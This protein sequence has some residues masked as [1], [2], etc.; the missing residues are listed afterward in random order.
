MTGSDSGTA[1]PGAPLELS[2]ELSAAGFE[3]AHEIGRGGFGIVFRCL[4]PS[5]DR[6]VAVKVLTSSL[7]Q[8]NLERFL[9]EQRAMGRLSGHPNIVNV[10]QVGATRG[11][12]PYIVMQ[13]HPRDSLDVRIRRDG[14]LKWDDALF[15]GVKMAGALETAHQLDVL[16]RDVKP[17]NILLTAYGDPQLTDFGIAHMAGAFE[18]TAGTVTGSPAFTAPEVLAGDSPSPRSDIYG[19]GATLFCAITGHAPFERHAGEQ[20]VAQFLRITTQPIPDLREHHIPDDVC[21]AIEHAMARS[22]ADRPAAAADFGQQLRAAEL[23]HSLP[24]DDMALPTSKNVVFTSTETTQAGPART[25]TDRGKSTATLAIGPT[26]PTS[27]AERSVSMPTGPRGEVGN[28]PL[29][30]TSFVGRRHALFEAKKTLSTSRLVTLTGMG[31]VGKTRLALR[32]AADTRRGFKDG[33]WLI[34]LGELHDAMLV[35]ATVATTLGIRNQ[36]ADPPRA[37]LTN[38]LMDRQLLLVL[39]NCEHLVETVAALAKTLLRACPGVRILATSREPLG[40][41]GEAAIRV[42]PLEVPDVDR[43]SSLRGLHQ[44]ESVNLFTAR[45]ATA[46][47]DFELTEQNK[48]AVARICQ[49][50]DGLPLPIELA[51]VRLRAMSA[52]QILDRLTDRFRI[53]TMGSRDAPT[54]QQTLKLCI[55]WSYELCTPQEQHLW[56]RLA[57]FAGSFELAAAETVCGETIPPDDLLDLLASLVDKS[58]LIREQSGAGVRYRLLDTLRDY[59][60][61][62]LQ[63]SGEYALLQRRH[64]DWYRRLADQA[65]ANWVS[66]HQLEWISHLEREQPN[67]RDALR[68][69]LTPS[70]A[71][72]GVRIATALFPFWISRGLLGEGRLWLGRVLAAQSGEPTTDRAKAL[73]LASVLAG[74][75]GEISDE[76]AL[77]ARGEAIRA[78]LDNAP[79]DAFVGYAAGCMALYIGEPSRA[80][81]LLED[82]VAASER[83]GH[84]FCQIASL[85]GLGLG[86]VLLDEATKA[87]DCHKRMIALTENRG[88]MVYRGRSSMTGGWA[89]W[90]KGDNDRATTELE[91]GLRLS[92][93]VDDRVGVARS[94][95]TMAWIEADQ[96]RAQRAAVLLGAA[97]ALWR[98]IGGPTA[99]FLDKLSYHTECVRSTRGILGERIYD[100]HFRQGSTLGFAEAAA[101]ALGEQPSPTQPHHS[102]TAPL[103]R[104][105]RQVAALVAEGL[106]N[107]LIAARLTISQRTAQGH[108]EHILTK[109]GFTS[110]TQIA[111]WVVEH[112]SPEL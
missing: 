62:R 33:V 24:V 28:L 16:H 6:T 108:V 11:G 13:Y 107:K 37:L 39:D 68:F 93:R 109:L 57:V 99:T 55:D 8:E 89:L 7:D 111:A 45:A 72:V 94:L 34:E 51:A 65:E 35:T 31:G 3:D 56:A 88:E 15:I 69:C 29:E 82:A 84:P 22:P 83:E 101:F 71:D 5:L 12:S 64:R 49:R 102:G 46:V 38:H 106:T 66:P 40:I 53:L 26:G 59:G 41:G 32:V 61:E 96:Q 73:Y 36:S 58:I 87:L 97:D 48:I 79:L 86:F 70:E 4:Q 100:K 103:T 104:R 75:Q 2:A 43:A 76:E 17:A 1:P 90:R 50:L 80:V 95:Q 81:S 42:P 110:R 74:M 98:E 52:R 10:L 44:Y 9:R 91:Q 85:L 78:R 23:K 77:F 20:I 54:R 18:T 21:E 19:L 67:F 63:I 30:L 27:T 112:A 47:P 92:N 14:P 60:Q 25:P 105:E